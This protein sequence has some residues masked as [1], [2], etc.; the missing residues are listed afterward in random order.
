[1]TQSSARTYWAKT[2]FRFL[3]ALVLFLVVYTLGVK[4]DQKGLQ[5]SLQSCWQAVDK[6]REDII[7]KIVKINLANRYPN[8]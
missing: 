5:T 6:K 8:A 4:S 2:S 7:F 1:M 3:V